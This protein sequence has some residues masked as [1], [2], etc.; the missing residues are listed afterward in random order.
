M[1]RYKPQILSPFFN[2]RRHGLHG[3]NRLSFIKFTHV[4]FK[5][6]NWYCIG[7]ING[8]IEKLDY[9]KKL[10]MDAI[11]INPHYDS[12]IRIMAMT[13]VIIKNHERIWRDGIFRSADYKDEEAQHAF[14]D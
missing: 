4:S 8:I 11:W 7:D 5:D 14:D 13:S 3:G 6:T 1:A 10:G 2:S 9:L 12:R